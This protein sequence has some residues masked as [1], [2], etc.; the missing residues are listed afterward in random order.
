MSVKVFKRRDHLSRARKTSGVSGQ[1]KK[2]VSVAQAARL[3]QDHGNSNKEPLSW[4]APSP[5]TDAHTKRQSAVAVADL[6]SQ[7]MTS[8]IRRSRWERV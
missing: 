5:D 2:R 4:L 8:Q 1:R 6:A 3:I 7:Q